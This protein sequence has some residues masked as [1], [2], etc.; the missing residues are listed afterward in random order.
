MRTDIV[1]A[2]AASGPRC[3]W[4][5]LAIAALSLT[6]GAAGLDDAA[7]QDRSGT[8]FTLSLRYRV[9]VAEGVDR[10]HT[11]TRS[12]TWPA[13][14][15]A[16]V[17]CDVWD[18]HHC[19][20]AVRRVREMAPRM[21]EFLIEARRRGAL[22]IH[23]PSECMQPYEGHPARRRAIDAPRAANL[24]ADIG[25]W[26]DRIP[27]EEKGVYPIDQ[28]DG[29][30]DDDPQEHAQ[31]RAQLQA[32]GRTPDAPWKKQIDLLEIRDED[33]ISDRG[34]EV[35]NVLEQRGIRHVVV[36][37]VHTN[38]CV[39]GRPFGLRQLAKN[40]KQVVLVRDLTDTM[41]NPQRPPYVQHHSGT[42]L[43]VEHI[44]KYVCPT[45]T[46]DQL[47][48]GRPFRF[49][50]DN[51]RHVSIVMAEDEYQTEKTLT[52][53]AQK[54]LR[55]DFR[56]SLF[57]AAA[58]DMHLLPGIEQ[59]AEADVA[60]ISVR[61]RILPKAQ[62][63]VFRAFVADGKAI[64]GLRTA[65]HAFSL[66]DGTVP[67]GHDVWPEFD[68]EV[69]GGN[70]QGHY[71]NTAADGP[72]TRVWTLPEARNH[73]VLQGVPEGEWKVTAWLYKTRP[74]G[75]AATPLMM[76]RV[77][78]QLPPEPVTWTNTHS[79]GG[80]VFYTSLGHPDEFKLPAFRRL[81]LNG[82]CWAAG[83]EVGKVNDD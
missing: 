49:S 75:S 23:A 72:T 53:F 3:L 79:G 80:R 29:G 69:L 13:A 17:V 18:S 55:R 62:L 44:E 60:V 41:Y 50:T 27:A 32:E 10:F 43:I 73:V 20:N 76:G 1:R 35:W 24:P 83:V 63:D 54:H 68:H 78:D 51:R 12:E 61:R 46:S 77:D 4:I 67:A 28:S 39:L 81:L 52:E 34:A 64:V 9:P 65:S 82:I 42:D 7:A 6:M 16:V 71:G 70:Y 40:G 25:Q 21:N 66:R 2:A 37:G 11:L 33:A 26:C 14:E 19:L 48:G 8:D 36:L 74:L 31:W 47:L 45:I 5:I 56:V 57:Y 58:D 59:L 30:E 15:T 38:M 22:I